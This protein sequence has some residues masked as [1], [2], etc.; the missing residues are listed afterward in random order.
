MKLHLLAYR[1]AV[2]RKPTPSRRLGGYIS[3]PRTESVRKSAPKIDAT[4]N[5]LQYEKLKINE[6]TLTMGNIAR[7]A[8][9]ASHIRSHVLK[10]G[11]SKPVS[12]PAPQHLRRPR[13]C[14]GA[15]TRPGNEVTAAG[16]CR[17]PRRTQHALPRRRL[18]GARC[19]LNQKV[20]VVVVVFQEPVVAGVGR[21]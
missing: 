21:R 2:R 5:T 15:R 6:P 1:S 8:R 7:P 11:C 10:C 12:T 20:I 19:Q 17:R 16:G 4:R 9:A 3:W 14:A 18:Q 13:R